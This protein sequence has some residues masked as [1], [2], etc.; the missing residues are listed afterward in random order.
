MLTASYAHNIDAATSAGAE[1]SKRLDEKEITTIT[2]GCALAPAACNVPLQD[3]TSF[4]SSAPQPFSPYR[5][6]QARTG[7][8][9]TGFGTSQQGLLAAGCV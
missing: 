1:V 2:L 3:G 9:Q 7:T 4:A 5:A 8:T 6:I